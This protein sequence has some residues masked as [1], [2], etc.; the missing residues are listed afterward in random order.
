MEPKKGFPSQWGHALVP[1][2]VLRLVFLSNVGA[3]GCKFDLIKEIDGEKETL[4][5][6]VQITNLWFVQPKDKQRHL[7]MIIM[8]GKRRLA[9]GVSLSEAC[10]LTRHSARLARWK[11]LEEDQSEG[12]ALSTPPAHPA[13][14]LSLLALSTPNLLC[15]S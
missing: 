5:L 13:W 12:S 4:K 3:M 9:A 10:M 6:A 15:Q 2:E 8:D 11:T 1:N 7:E 14:S